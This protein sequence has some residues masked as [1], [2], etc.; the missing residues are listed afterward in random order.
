MTSLSLLAGKTVWVYSDCIQYVYFF[1]TCQGI[2][3][4]SIAPTWLSNCLV[5]MA[6]PWRHRQPNI[7][8]LPV[9]QRLKMSA[10]LRLIRLGG[11]ARIQKVLPEGVQLWQRFF[12]LMRGK[13]IQKKRAIIGPP[14]KR[15]LNGVSLAGR[16]WPNMEFWLCSFVIFRGSTPVL[17]RNPL[18]LWFSGGKGVRPPAPPPPLDPHMVDVQADLSLRVAHSFC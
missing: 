4:R 1:L 9:A 17:I 8:S 16:W 13:R 3:R 11:Q 10:R 15:H 14:A 12:F 5:R 18:F 7:S 2:K 6:L